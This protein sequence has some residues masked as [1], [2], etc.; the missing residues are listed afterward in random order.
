MLVKLPFKM[1]Y[2]KLNFPRNLSH[3]YVFSETRLLYF[4]ALI[5]KKKFDKTKVLGNCIFFK[6]IYVLNNLSNGANVKAAI[7]ILVNCL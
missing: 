7:N 6:S 1:H 5:P 2:L 3:I 4:S